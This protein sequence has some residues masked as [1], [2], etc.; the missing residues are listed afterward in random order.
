MLVNRAINLLAALVISFNISIKRFPV[1]NDIY[2]FFSPLY[3]W[4]MTP[5]VKINLPCH[6]LALKAQ[7]VAGLNR[8]LGHHDKIKQI[9]EFRQ[10]I[11][12]WKALEGRV[13]PSEKIF[14]RDKEPADIG[15]NITSLIPHIPGSIQSHKHYGLDTSQLPLHILQAFNSSLLPDFKLCLHTG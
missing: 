15:A 9:N 8:S 14:G 4:L 2:R 5:S 3:L 10:N 7:S 12:E 13:R 1:I 11:S 6:L